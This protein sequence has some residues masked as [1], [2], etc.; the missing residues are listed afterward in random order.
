MPSYS[1]GQCEVRSG[2]SLYY[3]RWA[4]DAGGQPLVIVHGAGEHSGRYTKTAE[5]LVREGAIVYAF[6]LPGHGRSPGPRGH[7]GRF[8]HYLEAV[9]QVMR[10]IVEPQCRQQPILIGHSLGGL[11]ATWYSIEY[12][13]TIRSLILS[14]PLWGLNVHVPLWKQAIG[15]VLSPLWPSLTLARPYIGGEVLSHDPQVA[16]DYMSDPLVHFRASVRFYTELLHRVRALP[17]MLGQ[18]RV[19][20]LV[21]QAGDDRVASPEVVKRLFPV[22]G[23]LQK[24]LIVYDR[25]YH[26]VFNEVDNERVFQD[27]ADWI[28]LEDTGQT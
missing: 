1:E 28:R 4:P 16:A 23:S 10:L 24:R 20:L 6:D 3:Q 14:S 17:K 27:L 19:P 2:L 18:L 25:F 7:I 13:A 15:R 26:E 21:L 12:P 8:T 11:I 9:R 5:R 22:V